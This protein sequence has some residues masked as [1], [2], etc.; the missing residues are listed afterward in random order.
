MGRFRAV[1]G[2]EVDS[3]AAVNLGS[4]NMWAQSN[5]SDHKSLGKSVRSQSMPELVTLLTQKTIGGDLFGASEHVLPQAQ[6]AS[7]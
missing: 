2:R 1:C 3:K 4:A 6:G 5:L 7:L